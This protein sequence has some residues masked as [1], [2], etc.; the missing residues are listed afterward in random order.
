MLGGVLQH[1]VLIVID[2]LISIVNSLE[3]EREEFKHSGSGNLVV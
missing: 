3:S 2:S 1:T